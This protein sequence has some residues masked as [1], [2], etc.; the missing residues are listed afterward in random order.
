[1]CVEQ[2]II[3]IGTLFRHLFSPEILSVVITLS[4]IGYKLF[5]SITK[6]M[7]KDQATMTES[8]QVEFEKINCKLKELSSAVE[9]RNKETKDLADAHYRDNQKEI[10]RM[11][12]LDGMHDKRLSPTEAQYFYEKYK[13][14]GGNSFVTAKYEAYIRDYVAD[15]EKGENS[16]DD[17][18][19]D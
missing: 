16:K 10:L 13:A 1:M 8:F 7:R 4:G 6:R 18:K 3:D 11:Q 5:Q 12:L 14:V 19:L 15:Q 9:L 17:Q 2:L